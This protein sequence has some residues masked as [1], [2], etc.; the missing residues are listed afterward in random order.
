MVALDPWVSLGK[1]K[2]S[3]GF[4]YQTSWCSLLHKATF[5]FP[6]TP[7]G[8]PPDP[9]IPG[10]PPRSPDKV[11]MAER[12][13]KGSAVGRPGTSRFGSPNDSL[14]QPLQ[15]SASML[16]RRWPPSLLYA[17]WS[18]GFLTSKCNCLCRRGLP[19]NISQGIRSLW[20]FFRIGQFWGH[21]DHVMTSVCLV[22]PTRTQ[23]PRQS[24]LCFLLFFFFF[25]SLEDKNLFFKD[26]VPCSPGWL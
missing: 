12:C 18:P 4:S 7:L 8:G 1:K 3:N 25:F 11:L 20:R 21:Y 2:K 26:T 6:M 13:C 17:L 9:S 15:L 5:C 19:G 24:R 22:F 23:T 16:A 14:S 10:G